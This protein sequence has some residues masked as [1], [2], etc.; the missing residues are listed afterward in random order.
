MGSL[1]ARARQYASAVW[2]VA[3][4]RVL[5][6][7]QWGLSKTCSVAGM[8]LMARGKWGS[9]WRAIELIT[10][11]DEALSRDENDPNGPL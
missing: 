10:T 2:S 8:K 11:D 6:S 1:T 4:V 5:R 9:G 7:D 3:S